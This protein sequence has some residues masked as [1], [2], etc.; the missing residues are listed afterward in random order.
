MTESTLPTESS[1]QP[2]P[3]ELSGG[4]H[5]AKHSGSEAWPGESGKGEEPMAVE[6]PYALLQATIVPNQRV[7]REP[8][9]ARLKEEAYGLPLALWGPVCDDKVLLALGSEDKG[10]S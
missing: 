1:L 6:L 2:T 10:H 5:V 3:W 4:T 9:G 8:S 7:G